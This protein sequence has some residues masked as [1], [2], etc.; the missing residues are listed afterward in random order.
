M[1]NKKNLIIFFILGSAYYLIVRFTHFSIP[2]MFH[3]VTGWKCPGCGI[4]TMVMALARFDI[5]G[6]FEAN[7]FLFVSAP[8]IGAEII[9]MF[10]R[11]SE[12]LDIAKWNKVLVWA[13]LVMLIIF[14]VVRNII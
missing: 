14:G 11:R 8:L 12:G 2:C 1:V 5:V 4:T 3:L 7:P 6:A 9:Y 10:W 13:Y